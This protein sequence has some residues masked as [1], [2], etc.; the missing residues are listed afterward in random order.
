MRRAIF[1]VLLRN[2]L[3]GEERFC[4]GCGQKLPPKSKLSQQTVGAEEAE[5][6]G[7]KAPATAEGTAIVDLCLQCRVTRSNQLKHGY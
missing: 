1:R 6:Y 7:V 5:R 4:D 2:V 3:R